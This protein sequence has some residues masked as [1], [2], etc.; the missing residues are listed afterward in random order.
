MEQKGKCRGKESAGLECLLSTTLPGFE[1]EN[2]KEW[3]KCGE[4]EIAKL[5]WIQEGNRLE[6]EVW[7]IEECWAR[8]A[9]R[10]VEL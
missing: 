3:K 6:G 5:E 10:P 7:R 4:I 8:E 9:P 1:K 2:K